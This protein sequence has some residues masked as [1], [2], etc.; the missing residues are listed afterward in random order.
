MEILFNVVQGI[1]P[2]LNKNK[3]LL[4]TRKRLIREVLMP[5]LTTVQRRQRLQKIKNC[6][7]YFWRPACSMAREMI[8]IPKKKYE[9]LLNKEISKTENVEQDYKKN[10]NE[11]NQTNAISDNSKNA[12][13]ESY[14]QMKPTEFLKSKT[15]TK[16]IVK[17]RIKNKPTSAF[18]QKWLSFNI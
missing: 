4:V 10:V 9:Q 12:N 17:K 16:D 7:R 6:Y 2:I 11:K 18:K 5:R 15:K 8:L 3:T 13:D 1:C 14:V